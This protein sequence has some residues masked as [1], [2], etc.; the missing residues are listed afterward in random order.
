MHHVILPLAIIVPTIIIGEL[1]LALES[2]LIELASVAGVVGPVKLAVDFVAV[3]KVA[4][5][6]GAVLPV[7]LALAVLRVVKP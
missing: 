4:G 1:A 3:V 2:I 5:K 6:Y 7:L